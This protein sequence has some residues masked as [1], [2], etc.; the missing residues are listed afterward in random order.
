MFSNKSLV[1]LK[2][3]QSMYINLRELLLKPMNKE[4]DYIYIMI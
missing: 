2:A 1:H 4:G 3:V